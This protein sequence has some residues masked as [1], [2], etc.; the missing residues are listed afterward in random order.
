MT[1]RSTP[2]NMMLTT[3]SGGGGEEEAPIDDGSKSSLVFDSYPLLDDPD[4]DPFSMALEAVTGPVSSDLSRS[5]GTISA[6][7]QSSCPSPALEAKE[8]FGSTKSNGSHKPKRPLTAYS[9]FFQLERER[10]I[11]GTTD[12]P[13]TAQD[14][15]RTADALRTAQTNQIKRRS[16]GSKLRYIFLVGAL[17]HEWDLSLSLFLFLSHRHLHILANHPFQKSRSR[18]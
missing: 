18:Y 8:K 3:T 13:F 4:A 10:L 1:T 12:A 2:K 16:R 11:A 14:V 7:N 6:A 5:Q 17:L 15:T 9:I